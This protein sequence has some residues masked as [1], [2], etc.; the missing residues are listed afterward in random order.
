VTAA[1]AV[2]DASAAL[3]FL[4]GE[5][6]ATKVE[7]A[8]EAGA[9]IGAANWSEVAQKVRAHGRDWAMARAWLLSYELAIEPVSAVDAERAA[10]GWASRRELSLGDRLCLALGDRL[11]A[12]VVTADRAWGTRRPIRQ[13]R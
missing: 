6:G 8:L 1:P 11:G 9:T 10:E 12:E 5:E 4:L 7:R 13:I 2:L 3:A